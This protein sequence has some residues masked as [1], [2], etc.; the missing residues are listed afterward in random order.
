ME[1]VLLDRVTYKGKKVKAYHLYGA[2]MAAAAALYVTGTA[3]E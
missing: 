3:G 1:P 2:T